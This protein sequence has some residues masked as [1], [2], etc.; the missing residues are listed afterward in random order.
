[1]MSM[2]DHAVAAAVL[3][4]VWILISVFFNMALA[5]TSM[6]SNTILNA[7]SGLWVMLVAVVFQGAP[8]RLLPSLA[9]ACTLGGAALVAFSA[10]PTG[11]ADAPKHSLAGDGFSLLSSVSYA[12]YSVIIDR[13]IGNEAQA[14]HDDASAA[15]AADSDVGVAAAAAASATRDSDAVSAG[16]AVRDVSFLSGASIG[17]GTDSG[18]GC[19]SGAEAGKSRLGLGVRL[20]SS[21]GTAATGKSCNTDI[22]DDAGIILDIDASAEAD[23]PLLRSPAGTPSGDGDGFYD[24]SSNEL[25]LTLLAVAAVAPAPVP[26]AATAAAASLTHPHPHSQHQA[27]AQAQ[28]TGA[29]ATAKEEDSAWCGLAHLL[30]RRPGRVNIL[31]IFGFLGV[32][33]FCISLTAV[34]VM[35]VTGAHRMT[36]PSARTALLLAL[37]TGV[38]APLGDYCWAQGLLLTSP[39]VATL[40]TT[41][42]IPGAMVSDAVLHGARYSAGYALGACAVVAGF[43]LINLTPAVAAPPATVDAGAGAS[44]EDEAADNKERP[45]V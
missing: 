11:D 34:V 39:L 16:G 27:Q 38:G 3:A 9:M 5:M 26:A 12:L 28:L 6:A 14:P 20:S 1:M 40:G 30:R 36:V 45:L 24:G 42:T 31:L 44:K 29:E 22:D 35:H 41:M 25:G 17:V 33:N 19:S 4:P 43:V 7:T 21:V 8:L 23:G 13:L 10:A 32:Y 18:S 15:H 2:R 37:G